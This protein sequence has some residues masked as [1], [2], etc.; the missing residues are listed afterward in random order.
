VVKLLRTDTTLDLS[1]KAR[2]VKNHNVQTTRICLRMAAHGP[3]SYLYEG[4]T[5]QTR[6]GTRFLPAVN[7][8]NIQHFYGAQPSVLQDYFRNRMF[9]NR[10]NVVYS[11]GYSR[12]AYT[13]LQSD[14]K[15]R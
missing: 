11:K 3:D 1:Q 14:D 6:S 13:R 12:T 2:V 15:Y 7:V 10:E 4:V 9:D 8:F 5:K